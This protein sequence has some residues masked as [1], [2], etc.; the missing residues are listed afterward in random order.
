MYNF[1]PSKVSYLFIRP[2][3]GLIAGTQKEWA[4]SWRMVSYL[5]PTFEF[6]LGNMVRLALEAYTPDLHLREILRGMFPP[7]LSSDIV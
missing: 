7:L 5:A 6:D 1:V 3:Y 4:N 2:K